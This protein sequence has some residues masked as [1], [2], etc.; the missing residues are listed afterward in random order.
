MVP[1]SST[2]AKK[3]GVYTGKS[4]EE[5]TKMLVYTHT[6]KQTHTH[7][8][9]DTHTHTHLGGKVQWRQRKM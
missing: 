7:T 2:A 4:P 6:Q 5:V 8:H 3:V 1:I 9:T